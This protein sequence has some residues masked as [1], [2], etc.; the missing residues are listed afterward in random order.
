MLKTFP[1]SKKGRVLKERFLLLKLVS[2]FCCWCFYTVW[3]ALKGL[4]LQLAKEEPKWETL[5]GPLGRG[6]RWKEN[7]LTCCLSTGPPEAW[8][9]G[10]A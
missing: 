1:V 10:G 3:S 6:G 5:Q 7:I 4:K 8:G 2:P 9:W